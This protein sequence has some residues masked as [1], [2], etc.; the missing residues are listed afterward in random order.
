[1]GSKNRASRTIGLGTY[2]SSIDY[3]TL[4]VGAG[5]AGIMA[6]REAASRGSVL[7]IDTSPMPRDKSCGGMLN[8]YAQQ[9]LS[10]ESVPQE[11]VLDP[12]Y[13]N[14]RYWDWDRD[15]RKPTQLRF[16]NIDR[17]G[18][19]EW[20]LGLL[21]SNVEVAQ[22]TSLVDLAQSE[23]VTSTL[24]NGGAPYE[25]TCNNV[26]GADGARSAVR[27]TLGIGSVATYVTAQDFVSLEGELEPYFD[28]IYMREIGD[29][30]AY[31]YVVPK[32]DQAIVG[33][34][35][36]P[37]T[38]KPHDRHRQAVDTLRGRLPQ[39]GRSLKT[40]A[41]VALNVRSQG[42]VVRGRGRIMLAGEA[43]GFMSPTSG[44]GISYAMYS[45]Q[46]AG[47]AIAESDPE[48]ALE[49]YRVTT[50]H[51]AGNIK[52]K[53]K[54]LP[55]MESAAGKYVAGFMPTALVSSVTKGL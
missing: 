18:F 31:A 22:R 33:S 55:F 38:R 28:C 21:P 12:E 17:R 51:I 39:L 36:Y 49:R 24:R 5:P 20:M 53:L 16:R 52:R 19:D 37:K 42:D 30:F 25:V 6:A 54:W 40:E 3:D 23:H 9:F 43:A 11:L 27:R 46:L 10:D 8:E 14:F 41:G 48:S 50:D 29:S 26:I 13:V 35:F 1:M 45:G 32:G 15:I 34:V 47:K 44:E 7:L 4:V 2:V